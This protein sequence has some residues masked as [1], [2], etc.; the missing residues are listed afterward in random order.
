MN[1][2]INQQR[3]AW[4]TGSS[5]KINE[6]VS[7]IENYTLKLHINKIP[8]EGK[9]LTEEDK[10]KSAQWAKLHTVSWQRWKN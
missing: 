2:L 10:N 8:E 1:S 5:S 9:T 3:V 7:S 4:F 6:T